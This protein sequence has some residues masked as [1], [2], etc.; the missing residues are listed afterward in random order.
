M[1]MFDFAA[2]EHFLPAIR[3]GNLL[4]ALHPILV[5]HRAMHAVITGLTCID[6]DGHFAELVKLISGE[7]HCL[8]SVHLEAVVVLFFF[9]FVRFREFVRV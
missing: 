2:G 9:C 7:V 3:V 8:S 4:L 6:Y 5:Q 1:L